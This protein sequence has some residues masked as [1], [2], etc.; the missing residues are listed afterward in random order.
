MTVKGQVTVP[1]E[2]RDAFGLRPG[3]RVEFLAEA[4]GVKIVKARP[5]KKGLDVVERLRRAPW[6]RAVSTRRLMKLTRGA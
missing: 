3:E 4:D 5:R 6:N 2:L 1:K